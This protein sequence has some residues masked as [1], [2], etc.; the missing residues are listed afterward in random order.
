MIRFGIIGCGNISINAHMAAFDKL[1]DKVKVSAVC[2]LDKDRAEKA[3]EILGAQRAFSDYREMVD[4]VDA[5]LIALP[6]RLH[7]SVGMFFAEHKKHILMEKPLCIKESE[8][9]SLIAKTKEMN[10]KLM[11]AYPVRHWPE[12]KKLKE[13]MDD[14]MCGDVFQMT[15]YTD[16]YN[17]S[18]DTRGA[19]MNC[20]GLGGGQFFSHGCHYV[21][22]L[23]WFLGNPVSGTHMGT[24]R[25]TPWMDREGTSHVVIK[26]EDGAL[27]YHTGSWGAIGTTHKFKVDIYGT[28][29]TL[30]YC[31]DGKNKEHIVFLKRVTPI[32]ENP[33]VVW[34]PDEESV[35]V[36]WEKEA[37]GKHSEGEI[38]HF[39]SCILNDLKPITDGE[40]SLQGLRVIWKMYEAEAQNTVADLR[41]LGLDERFCDKP[42]CKFDCDSEEA[43][44]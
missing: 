26:F 23:L 32:E 14:G 11:T 36:L 21:D 29:G 35:K 3:A 44:Y 17:P 16:H 30:S 38:E 19:W 34:L 41:G 37:S 4:Y 5:V 13:F 42:L 25:G 8:A 40:I 7:Y 12:I 22:I 43:V 31:T 24:N 28:K 2:D 27:G 33:E 9:L 20:K 10:V 15:V 18:R 1:K 39:V 6:H